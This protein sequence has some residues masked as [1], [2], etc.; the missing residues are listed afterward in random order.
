MAWDQGL[1]P[2]N[3]TSLDVSSGA[4]VVVLTQ[5]EEILGNLG[6]A[7]ITAA[8]KL[9]TA[10]GAPYEFDQWRLSDLQQDGVVYPGTAYP[11]AVATA[12]GRIATGVGSVAGEGAG[13][14]VFALD[15]PVAI[16]SLLPSMGQTDQLYR[17]GLAMS[18]D[19]TLVFAVTG[20]IDPQHHTVTVNV[21]PI[22]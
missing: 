5:R 4:P 12:A 7:V 14:H 3:L 15:R 20:S 9:V 17:R 1:E 19:G 11:V 16:A 18:P 8:G 22:P 6:D 21:L 10:S 2:A 13:V